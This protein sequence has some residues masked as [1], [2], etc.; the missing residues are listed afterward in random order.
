MRI[1]KGFIGA[2]VCYV[3]FSSFT[4]AGDC[5]DKNDPK[6]GINLHFKNYVDSLY[7]ISQA[8]ESGLCKKV[9]EK[10]MVGYY[11]VK[12]LNDS[13]LKEPIL[14][15]IDYTQKS[16]DKRLWVIDLISGRLL[17]NTLVAHGKNSGDQ[18]AEHFSNELSSNMSSI[19][20]FITGE[21]YNGKHGESMAL[22]GLD[23]GFNDHVRQR[24]VVMHAADYVTE[25]F[26]DK[27]G[28][29]GRSQGCPAV[30]PK[31]AGPII[32]TIANGSCLFVYYPD[33]NYQR[34]TNLLNLN[35]AVS[36]FSGIKSN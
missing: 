18:Y 24:S 34:S 32:S 28:R 2:V 25:D 26:I 23:K 22:D 14:S 5:P 21:I 6:A 27:I 11:N 16:T 20:F 4:L 17:Y 7:K 12:A 13:R 10:A 1:I 3:L 35:T 36:S 31:F 19:G 8:A 33:E 29:I 30:P 15:I 9:F